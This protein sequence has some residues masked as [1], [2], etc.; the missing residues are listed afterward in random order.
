MSA[1]FSGI[2]VSVWP[3]FYRIAVKFLYKNMRSWSSVN[4]AVFPPW[5]VAVTRFLFLYPLC[6]PRGSWTACFLAC[7]AEVCPAF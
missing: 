4:V 6:S 3:D 1:L 5:I 2:P 7:T